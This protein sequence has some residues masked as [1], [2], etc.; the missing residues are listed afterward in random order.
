MANLVPDTKSDGIVFPLSVFSSSSESDEVSLGVPA[1]SFA[2]EH[3][4]MKAM[5]IL[6]T[7]EHNNYTF[8]LWYSPLLWQSSEV[9]PITVSLPIE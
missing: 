1:L 9:T 8:W 3:N 2:R 5:I 7:N 6:Y 4:Y